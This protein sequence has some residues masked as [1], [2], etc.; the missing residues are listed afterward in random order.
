MVK[1]LST[2][3]VHWA[4]VYF[5]LSGGPAITFLMNSEQQNETTFN[6]IYDKYIKS[7]YSISPTNKK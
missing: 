6:E 4:A 3:R 2:S 5:L 7:E 1:L